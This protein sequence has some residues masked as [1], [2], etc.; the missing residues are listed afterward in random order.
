MTEL[1]GIHIHPLQTSNLT[2][3]K[4]RPAHFGLVLDAIHP[5]DPGHPAGLLVPGEEGRAQVY[6]Q[7]EAVQH[8]QDSHRLQLPASAGLHLHHHEGLLTINTLAP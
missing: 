5:A 3:S 8:R 4:S 2:I 7:P 1:I 6:G